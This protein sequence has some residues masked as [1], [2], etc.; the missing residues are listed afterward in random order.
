MSGSLDDRYALQ[1]N[2]GIFI[3]GGRSLLRSNSIRRSE[4]VERIKGNLSN[5]LSR[6]LRQSAA[7]RHNGLVKVG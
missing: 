1:A 7:I 6:T 4:A 5:I 2:S 3:T